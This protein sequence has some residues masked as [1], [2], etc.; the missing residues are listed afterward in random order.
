MTDEVSVTNKKIHYPVRV[1]LPPSDVEFDFDYS[2]TILSNKL[3]TIKNFP[4]KDILMH[5]AL[6]R[7]VFW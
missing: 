7:A 2:S 6:D 4:K 1:I 3:V 5:I